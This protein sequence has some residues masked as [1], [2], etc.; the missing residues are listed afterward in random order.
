MSKGV[1]PVLEVLTDQGK[2]GN[3]YRA[4]V[5]HHEVLGRGVEEG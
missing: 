4:G 2:R 1:T 3:I 5:S